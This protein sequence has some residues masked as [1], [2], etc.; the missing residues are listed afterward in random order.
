M[1]VA[2]NI[3]KAY[4]I[5]GLSD[6]E[7]FPELA[8]SLGRAFVVFLRNHNLIKPGQA[9]VVGKDMRLTSPGLQQALMRGVKDETV[10]VVDIGLVSTPL[11]NFACANYPEHAGG[12]MVTASHNPAQYNGFKMTLGDGLPVGEAF[13]MAEIKELVVN[14]NFDYKDSE[15]LVFPKKEVLSDYL[16]KI[17]SI[18]PPSSLRSM[19]LVIDAGNGMAKV[20]FPDMLKHLSTSVEYLYL[21]PDGNFPNH[22]ANP[23]KTETLVDLQ[24]KVIETGADFGFALDGDA[25]R[26]GLV[27]EKGQVV[28]ASFVGALIGVEVLRNHAK[29]KMLYDVRSSMI[30]PELWQAAGATTEMCKVGHANI[31]KMLKETGGAFASELSLH[32]YYKD[33]F[34]VESTD[35][36]LLYVLQML[37]RENK[38]LSEIVAPLQKYFHSGE[39]NFE[40]EDKA[41]TMRRVEEKYKNE[42]LE[43]SRL[44][45]LWM[46]FDWGWA[47]VRLSNTEPVVRL[48]LETKSKE[49]MEEKVKELSEVIKG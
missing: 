43:I 41:E 27:D 19:K 39:I 48:N 31:K 16:N 37:S 1:L 23:L 26:I 13:G 9:V 7:L 2:K 8:Y 5:R 14:S 36:S 12:V 42:A 40:V 32:L 25:D 18:V 3:F 20:T 46:K 15:D 49:V 10:E 17:F 21:E 28:D 38:P 22:E 11:F 6:T 30:I 24:K 45:G 33:T 44:D 29:A 34:D 35:L 4:D 47:S